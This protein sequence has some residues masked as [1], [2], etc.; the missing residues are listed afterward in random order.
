MTLSPGESKSAAFAVNSAMLS[1]WTQDKEYKAEPG[2][3]NLWIAPNSSEGPMASFELTVSGEEEYE[4]L[5][6]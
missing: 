3:F 4:I 6:G 5:E 2:K 1:F